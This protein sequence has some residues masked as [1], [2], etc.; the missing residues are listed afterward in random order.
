MAI[1]INFVTGSEF[2]VKI[3]L[4]ESNIAKR[5]EDRFYDKSSKCLD[6]SD[7]SWKPA[8]YCS[9]IIIRGVRAGDKPGDKQF[10]WSENPGKS[11]SAFSFSFLRV[12]QLFSRFPY[13]Y[14]AG[15]IFHPHLKTP[16]AKKIFKVLCAFPIDGA[17]NLRYG[18]DG[19]GHT[20]EFP[21]TSRS[22]DSQDITTFE[23]WL[24]VFK[25]SL[26]TSPDQ[27]Q[28]FSRI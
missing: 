5:L 24:S 14:E 23:K 15:F 10:A 22:C 11:A 13:D 28:K 27:Q 2:S 7:N 1:S 20:D 8:F 3:W 18:I 19:C 26:H 9:G 6:L 17:T 21:V 4:I 16:K 25:Y 12:D